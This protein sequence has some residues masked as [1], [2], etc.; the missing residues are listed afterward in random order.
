MKSLMN[1]NISRANQALTT[2]PIDGKSGKDG[3]AGI[4]KETDDKNTRHEEKIIR[5]ALTC[6]K[7]GRK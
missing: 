3:L 5:R 7:E 6:I 1:H 4:A 2:E